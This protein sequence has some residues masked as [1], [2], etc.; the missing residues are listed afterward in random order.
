LIYRGY[1]AAPPVPA[2]FAAAYHREHATSADVR[3]IKCIIGGV[4]CDCMHMCNAVD[5]QLRCALAVVPVLSTAAPVIP[6]P[7]PYCCWH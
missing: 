4:R 3:I 6:L 1:F 5:Q 2:G 7:A